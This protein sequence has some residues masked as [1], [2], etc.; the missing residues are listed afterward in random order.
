LSQEFDGGV[1]VKKEMTYVCF[2]NVDF[3]KTG[4]DTITVPMIHW[5][6]ADPLPLEI[7]EGVP[8]SEGARLLFAGEHQAE[9][10]W[11]TYKENTFILPEAL[12]GRRTISLGTKQI[13]QR[14]S[15]KGFIFQENNPA[16]TRLSALSNSRIF[17][18]SF[19]VNEQAA[20][21]EH[22]GNNVTVEFDELDF[23][24]GVHSLVVYGRTHN[25]KN[26]VHV[27]FS[28]DGAE[29][30][31]LLEFEH[32]ARMREEKFALDV[33]AGVHKV[34]FWFLPG[35]DFDFG[36]FEFGNL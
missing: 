16:Y 5:H 26:T 18:D 21:I 25:A 4:S 3:G 33:A 28:K 27:I 30:R 15:L 36:W 31:T 20:M 9:F 34:T 12:T 10:T 2:A 23:D 32:S 17:G 14:A 22:I 29:E 24:K 11:Q 35:C 13:V 6:S 1:L 8:G 19:T 7:W